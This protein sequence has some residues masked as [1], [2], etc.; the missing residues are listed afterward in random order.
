MV[1][2]YTSSQSLAVQKPKGLVLQPPK[3]RV[4]SEEKRYVCGGQE[5]QGRGVTDKA[6]LSADT[7]ALLK[8]KYGS[9]SVDVTLREMSQWWTW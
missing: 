4:H 3:S 1:F 7:T 2:R 5:A 8:R 9:Q 6:P